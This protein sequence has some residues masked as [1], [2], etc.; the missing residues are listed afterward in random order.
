MRTKGLAIL[1]ALALAAGAFANTASPPTTLELIGSAYER[2]EL[3]YTDY[4]LYKLYLA[5]GDADRIPDA[6]RGSDSVAG[7]C[8]TLLLYDAS[9]CVIKGLFDEAE[10]ADAGMYLG[11]P[12]DEAPPG[13]RRGYDIPDQAI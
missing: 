5:F 13:S 8:G 2:G 11:R 10:L 12:T 9:Y 6:Y 4:A 1:I 3:V 7:A